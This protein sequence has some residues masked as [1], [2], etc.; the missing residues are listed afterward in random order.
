M[1][2]HPPT[3]PPTHPPPTPQML[4]IPKAF[5]VGCFGP[6]GGATLGMAFGWETLMTATLVVRTGGRGLWAR[7]Q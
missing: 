3:H 4:L 2:H 6:A 5:A 1:R 7:A